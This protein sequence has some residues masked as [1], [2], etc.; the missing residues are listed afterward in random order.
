[1]RIEAIVNLV[2]VR[3]RR[4][5]PGDIQGGVMRINS[6]LFVIL[7]TTAMNTFGQQ[8]DFEEKK[9]QQSEPKQ[10]K[11]QKSKPVL[12]KKKQAKEGQAI[13]T[14]GE[15]FTRYTRYISCGYLKIR[16]Q[17]KLTGSV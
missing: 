15:S 5:I 3:E 14:Y 16:F 13:Y 7:F 12:T 11:G 1:L 4:E 10:S 17:I 9:D 6:S 8:Q 2:P